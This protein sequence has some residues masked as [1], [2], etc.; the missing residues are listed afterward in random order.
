MKISV[1]TGKG[2][3]IVATL[4]HNGD[5]QKGFPKAGFIPA[6]GQT[7]HEIDLPPELESLDSAEELHRALKARLKKTPPKRGT[8][9]KK[10]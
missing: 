10:R 2:G 7:L 5:Q 4:R 1:V 9:T 6:R 8:P 3:A